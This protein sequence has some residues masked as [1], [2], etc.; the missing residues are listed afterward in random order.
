MSGIDAVTVLALAQSQDHSWIDADEA[1]R[2]AAGAADAISAVRAVLTE[3]GCA[4]FDVDSAGFLDVLESL[5]EA[6]R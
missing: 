6:P 3:S 1:A 4:L 5:A 2:I